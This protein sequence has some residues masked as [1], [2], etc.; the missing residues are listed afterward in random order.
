VISEVADLLS[1]T[2]EH[3]GPV[4]VLLERD[5]EVPP[6]EALIAE[7]KVLDEHY[8]LGLSRRESRAESA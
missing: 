3:T 6:L 8:Q 4:P 5:N 2:V 1:F 7:V